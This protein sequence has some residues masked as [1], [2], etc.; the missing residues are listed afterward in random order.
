MK[1]MIIAAIFMMMA[2]PDI[3]LA[4]S[5]EADPLELTINQ[6]E[7]GVQ[8]VTIPANSQSFEV[9]GKGF[10]LGT[11]LSVTIN[12]I[13]RTSV[14]GPWSQPQTFTVIFKNN[15]GAQNGNYIIEYEAPHTSGKFTLTAAIRAGVEIPKF[16]EVAMPISA[17]IGLVFFLYN[18]R[19]KE[20]EL[21]G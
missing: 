12:G 15:K 21:E 2:M 7:T 17:T 16:P 4:A 14:N 1:K 18:Y 10:D 19:N 5:I 6:D 20:E 8:M 13:E 11:T 9:T 3:V